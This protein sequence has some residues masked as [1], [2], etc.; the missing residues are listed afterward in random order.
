M[1]ANVL[2]MSGTRPSIL[3]HPSGMT[4]ELLE[5]MGNDLSI[6]NAARVSYG[7]ESTYEYWRYN[8]H[9]QQFERR[10]DKGHYHTVHTLDPRKHQDWYACLSKADAGLLGYLMRKRHGTP[11]EMVQ[12]KFRVCAPIAV[13]WEWVR[14]RISSFNIMS[15]RYVEWERAFYTPE[16][17]DWRV[18]IGKP[19]HYEFVPMKQEETWH[20]TYLYNSYME[21]AFDNYEDLLG[22]GVPKEIARNLLP[23]GAMTQMVWSVNLRS[24]LN[25]LS[26]RTAPDAL[27]EI[28]I[29][30]RMVEQYADLVAP[31]AMQLWRQC[32]KQTP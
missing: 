20:N 8:L 16:F 22:Q 30:A 28:Q 23:M 11:F 13:I 29:C 18:Q 1:G 17:E 14:H 6:V 24:L 19:G 5:S 4:V 3:T 7:K 21:Q 25:F 10:Q 32:G 15:T 31:E 9:L 26:L 12:F 27:R 2:V